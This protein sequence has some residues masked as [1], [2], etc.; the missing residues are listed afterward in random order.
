MVHS[1]V[2]NRGFVDANKRTA[3]LLV[4]ILVDRSGY[5]LDIPDDEPV[6]DLIVS[7]ATGFQDLVRWFQERLVRA[8]PR[9]SPLPQAAASASA[10]ARFSKA[11]A[12][13]MTFF[14]PR[15]AWRMRCSFSTRPSRT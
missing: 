12:F 1:T 6:D 10:L 8:C 2:G 13:C 11:S 15:A 4:E 7:V 9:A 5:R 3:W 14:T